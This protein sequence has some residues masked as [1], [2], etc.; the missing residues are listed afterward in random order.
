MRP[1]TGRVLFIVALLPLSIGCEGQASQIGAPINVSVDAGLPGPDQF[2]APD[3]RVVSPDLGVRPDAQ[4]QLVDS[5]SPDQTSGTTVT[6][7]P[8][9]CSAIN[10]CLAQ[11]PTCKAQCIDSAAPW[12]RQLYLSMSNCL[13][14]QA[15]QNCLAACPG[16]QFS[17]TASCQL[18]LRTVCK[19][20]VDA[21]LSNL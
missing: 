10:R 4:A 14:L 18:C 9:S 19:Q 3:Q 8:Q 16:G 20:S 17:T 1:L 15:A 7:G 21:C 5:L 6:K 2:V 13:T 11:C 12:A